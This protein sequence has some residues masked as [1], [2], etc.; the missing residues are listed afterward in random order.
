[1]ACYSQDNGCLVD[2]SC[3]EVKWQYVRE[4]KRRGIEGSEVVVAQVGTVFHKKGN[5]YDG[6][7]LEDKEQTFI[8]CTVLRCTV[9]YYNGRYYSGTD[10]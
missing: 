1:M 6:N 8:T 4:R 7:T 9:L 10:I 3:E 2:R 5:E